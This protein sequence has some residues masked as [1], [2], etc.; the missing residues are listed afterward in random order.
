MTSWAGDGNFTLDPLGFWQYIIEKYLVHT[1]RESKKFMHRIQ[2]TSVTDSIKEIYNC[3]SKY[4]YKWYKC[5]FRKCLWS[6]FF[7]F[8]AEI[9]CWKVILYLSYLLRIVFV[10]HYLLVGKKLHS[11][12]RV[13]HSNTVAAFVDC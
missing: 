13:I 9:L 8:S 1:A 4:Q 12:E 2:C 7:L 5:T 10:V 11:L 6:L 3:C